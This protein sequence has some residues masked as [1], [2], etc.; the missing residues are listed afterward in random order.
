MSRSLLMWCRL[1]HS[2]QKPQLH[3]DLHFLSGIRTPKEDV[4]TTSIPAT[5][6]AET[7]PPRTSGGCPTTGRVG[8]RP[9]LSTTTGP[10]TRRNL[11]LCST[12]APLRLRSRPRTPALHWSGPQRPPPPQPTPGGT[13]GRHEA[14]TRRPINLKQLVHSRMSLTQPIISSHWKGIQL[15]L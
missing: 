4:A 13:A 3:D 6:K 1:Q 14:S 5:T 7:L 9:G 12:R 15:S 2:N 11:L 8:G 10:S